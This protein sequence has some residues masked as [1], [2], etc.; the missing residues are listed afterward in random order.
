MDVSSGGFGVS[1][2]EREGREWE[3]ERERERKERNCMHSRCIS[4]TPAGGLYKTSPVQILGMLRK[5][6]I[7]Q[8]ALQ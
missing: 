4:L 2:V 7:C 1:C 3:T 6:V 5:T 8:L